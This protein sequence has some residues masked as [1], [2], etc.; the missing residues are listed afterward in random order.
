MAEIKNNYMD[1]A[2]KDFRA[3]NKLGKPP[4]TSP[5]KKTVFSP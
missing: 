2:T 5:I 4:E 1:S 3:K